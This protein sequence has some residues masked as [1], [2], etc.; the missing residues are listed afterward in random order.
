VKVD[1][2]GEYI[3]TLI[4]GGLKFL[5]FGHHQE[6]LD[7]L[8]AAVIKAC[9]KG[10]RHIRIDGSTGM[11]DRQDLVRS[12]QNDQNVQVMSPPPESLGIKF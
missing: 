8:E 5:V 7:G 9:G 1:A 3:A 6:V 11:Q 2:A 12:F 4:E 10:S